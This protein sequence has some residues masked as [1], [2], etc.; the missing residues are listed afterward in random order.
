MSRPATKKDLVLAAD[1]QFEKLWKLIDSMT[2]K[3]QN[4]TFKFED[5][6]KNVRDV[7]IHL[8]EWHQLLLNWANANRK[9]EQK[10]FLP[11]PYN[12]KTYPQMN[13]EI[14]K[15]HQ[16]TPLIDSKKM[17]HESHSKVMNL[18]ESFSNDELFTKKYF[19]WTGGSTLGSYCVSTTSS[20]YDWA[21][22]KIK[23]HIKTNV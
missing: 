10:T 1:E 4:D 19:S 16:N 2:D 15:K 6:D 13:V 9:G 14:W 17:L 21:M 23:M 5:R 12:W 8:Y 22:K 3:E 18:I 11:E 7:L 20:H